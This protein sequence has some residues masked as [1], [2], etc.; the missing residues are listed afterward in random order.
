MIQWFVSRLQ[1]LWWWVE[2]WLVV[3]TW[4]METTADE[5]RWLRGLGE[6]CSVMVMSRWT[7]QNR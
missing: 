2:R 3:A 1:Q 7:S 5:L 4:S 6:G